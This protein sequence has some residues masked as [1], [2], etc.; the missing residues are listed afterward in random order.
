M[1]HLAVIIS[2]FFLNS[3]IMQLSWIWVIIKDSF[4]KIID[5]SSNLADRLPVFYFLNWI[6][7][8]L[9]ELS[10]V[11]F[12]ISHQAKWHDNRKSAIIGRNWFHINLR[13]V[14]LDLRLQ[15]SLLYRRFVHSHS[16]WNSSGFSS[17]KELPSIPLAKDK[18]NLWFV[19]QFLDKTLASSRKKI[20]FMSQVLRKSQ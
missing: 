4:L 20:I 17:C 8:M 18:M 12:T 1:F 2:F 3:L 10:M 13:K 6:L 7:I 19:N 16:L 5:D 11:H 15:F 9:V 14:M